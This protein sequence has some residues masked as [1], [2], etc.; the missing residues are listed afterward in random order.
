MSL[1]SNQSKNL[2]YFTISVRGRKGGYL[3]PMDGE[4]QSVEDECNIHHD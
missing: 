4:E 1:R 2:G 3:G